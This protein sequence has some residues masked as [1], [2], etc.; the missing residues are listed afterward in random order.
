M[1]C[2]DSATFSLPNLKI[3]RAMEFSATGDY[4]P[5]VTRIPLRKLQELRGK[6]GHWSVRNQSMAAE[7]PF[8]GRLLRS[9][10]GVISPQGAPAG[11]KQIYLDSWDSLDYIRIQ[12]STGGYFSQSYVGAFSRVLSLG[13]LLSCPSSHGRAVWVGSDATLTQC[14]A[15]YYTARV[16]SVFSYTF[17]LDFLSQITGLPPDDCFLISLSEFLGLLCFLVVRSDAYR[18]KLVA[19]AGDNQNVVHWIK[20]RRPKNKIAQFFCRILNRIEVDF[21]FLVFPFY[22]STSHNEV[23]DKLSRLPLRSVLVMPAPRV[24]LWLKL[25]QPSYGFLLSA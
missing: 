4:D 6:L 18:D 11:G 25:F 22:I 15:V 2:A 21:S 14:A 1:V 9:R 24:F 20:Y 8:I 3:D 17:A 16:A 10:K 7:A 23:C 12:M 5:V 13:E 19:Y